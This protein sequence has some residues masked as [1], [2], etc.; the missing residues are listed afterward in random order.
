MYRKLL[1][2]LAL[3]AAASAWADTSLSGYNGAR[4]LALG[5]AYLGL[6]DDGYSLYSNPA[7]ITGVK[8]FNV[9]SLYSQ[10]ET[11]VAYASIGAVFPEAFGG[12]VGVAY[13]RL[14]LSGFQAS[15]ETVDYA[16]QEAIIALARQYGDQLSAG[17]NVHFFVKGLS[18]NVSGFEGANGSGS[19]IDLALKYRQYSWLSLGLALQ[20]LA[21]RIDYRDGSRQQLD[22]TIGL[23]SSFKLLGQGALLSREAHEVTA[24]LD[25]SQNGGRPLLLHSGLEWWPVRFLAARFGVEQS[26]TEVQGATTSNAVFNN[27]TA[28]LGLK[29]PGFSFDYALYRYGDSTGDQVHYFS[30]SYSEVP[31]TDGEW[32]T[33]TPEAAVATQESQMVKRLKRRH[34]SD[35]PK[36]YWAREAIELL[37]TAGIMDGYPDG[38]FRPN[39]KMTRG[40]F[41][42]ILSVARSSMPAF[43]SEP[44]QLLSR[45]AAAKMLSLTGNVTRPK[46]A[47]T[48]AE[49]AQMIYKTYWAQAFLKRLPPIED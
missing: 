42:T 11:G 44:D 28:G 19:A 5:N 29:F 32:R 35:V 25:L 36:N 43:V 34:F 33:S 40:S 45:E 46:A 1:L 49:A 15:A 6:A 7:G 38:R 20:D 24:N 8:T 10:P 17:L 13:K 23:G 41:D 12:W 3:C 27:L 21:G 18:R 16:D 26:F 39:L 31:D 14:S 9:V 47:I 2:V 22:P 4:P 37:A 48:R 30:L